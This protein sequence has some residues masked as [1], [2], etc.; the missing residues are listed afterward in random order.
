MKRRAGTPVAR[1]VITGALG[2]G[3]LGIVFGAGVQDILSQVLPSGS[4]LPG[5]DD[6]R[7]YSVTGSFPDTPTNR[8]R[9]SVGG[10]VEKPLVLNYEQLRALSSEHLVRDFQ[11]VTGWRVPNVPW[12]GVR[13][14]HVIE[15]ARPTAAAKAVE[16]TSYDGLYTESLTIEEAHRYDVLVAYE[17]YGKPLSI[18]H[19][20][21]VRL[22]VAPMYGY[23]SCKWLKSIQ[24]V[25]EATPG[26]WEQNGYAVEGWIG[27][28]NGRSDQP[29]D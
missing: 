6:F 1:R 22:Y 16:F 4:L 13:L 17:M 3:I 14:D 2:L 15:L 28:S 8:Y 7:I 27:R 21:P 25:A 26:F 5:S 10:L 18:E 12:T 20:G 23:K 9:L 19:G 11:C 29:V 24:L